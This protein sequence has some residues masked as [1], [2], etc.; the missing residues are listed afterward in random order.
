MYIYE[1]LT[2]KAIQA[3]VDRQRWSATDDG[4][5]NCVLGIF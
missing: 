1:I 5:C 4:Y 3:V 2:K